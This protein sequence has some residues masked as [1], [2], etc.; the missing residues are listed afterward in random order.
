MS[1]G[2]VL[3]CYLD[4]DLRLGHD[5]LE[6]VAKR[7]GFNTK[8]LTPGQFLVFI[9]RKKNRIKIYAANDTLAYRRMEQGQVL[10]LAT[11][12]SIPRVFNGSGRMF[13]EAA[14]KERIVK[15]LIR[16]R[17]NVLQAGRELHR[18]SVSA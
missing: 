8:K 14:L 3:R 11:I 6:Q 10:D 4:Q 7:D 16:K 13:Y 5:G 18:M 1:Q 9:N 17:P 2:V 12:A 15:A